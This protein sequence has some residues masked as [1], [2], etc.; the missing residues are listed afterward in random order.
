MNVV[1]HQTVTIAEAER[2]EITDDGH[3][4]VVGI[5][6]QQQGDERRGRDGL[7]ASVPGR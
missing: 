1:K 7:T 5:R 3:W 4:D 2:V 6:K